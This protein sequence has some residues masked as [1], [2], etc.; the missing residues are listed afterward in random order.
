MLLK[1]ALLEPEVRTL[2][3]LTWQ[4]ASPDVSHVGPIHAVF[5]IRICGV[6]FD[7]MLKG[8]SISCKGN[9]SFA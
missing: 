5:P 6:D 1:K 3:K 4:Q 9:D 7:L 2:E 8:R